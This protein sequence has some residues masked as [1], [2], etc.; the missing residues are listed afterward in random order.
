MARERTCTCCHQV[1]QSLWQTF[2]SFDLLHSSHEWIQTILSDKD[3]AGDLERLEINMRRTLVHCRQSHVRVKLDVQEQT[4]CFTQFYGSCRNVSRC[5]FTDG[6]D[7][8]SRSLGFSDWSISFL[9]KP[10]QQNQRWKR[11]T[12]KPVGNSSIKHAKTNSNHEHQSGSDQHWSRSI[13]RNTFWFQRYCCMSL[14]ITK[15]WLRW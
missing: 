12:G 5:R 10:N 11:A 1:D 9:T 2:S 15:T 4:W 3:F 6:C 8:R 7:S 13:K 14:R